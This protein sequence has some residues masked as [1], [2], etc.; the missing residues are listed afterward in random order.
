MA[1]VKSEFG[2]ASTGTAIS[3][4]SGAAATNAALAWLGGGA[5]AA[6]GG[7]MAA[8]EAILALA[9]PIGWA[10]A[11]ASLVASGLLIWKRVVD[12]NH[13]ND[14]FTLRSSLLYEKSN[15]KFMGNQEIVTRKDGLYDVYNN[16]VMD[17]HNQY[18]SY[19][20]NIYLD[21]KFETLGVNHL[22]TY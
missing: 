5:I 20:G 15:E 13:L 17:P 22:L 11:A 8:G 2:V 1:V 18:E 3:S 9:E 7:G 12:K 4:L 21:S 6:G 19:S 16:S 14:I 10:I